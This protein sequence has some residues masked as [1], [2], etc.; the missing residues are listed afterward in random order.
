[1]MDLKMVDQDWSRKD[2]AAEAR[3]RIIKGTL[4][5]KCQLYQLY[6]ADIE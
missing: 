3:N 6:V 4:H 5:C 1:M 2:P